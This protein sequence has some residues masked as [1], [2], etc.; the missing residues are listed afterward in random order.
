LQIMACFQDLSQAAARW[1]RSADGFL[2]LFGTKVVFPGIGERRTLEALSLLVG[3]WDRPYTVFNTS[4]G[5]STQFGF[6][7]GFGVARNSGTGFQHSSRREAQLTPAEIANVP[8]GHALVVRTSRWGLVQ[9]TPFDRTPTWR[10][11]LAAA[12]SVVLPRGGVD[13]LETLAPLPLPAR[14]RHRGKWMKPTGNEASR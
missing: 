13:I 6:P 4:T 2:T 11:V 5:E 9:T 7:L 12:P 3:D 14:P 1:G 10:T 8:P